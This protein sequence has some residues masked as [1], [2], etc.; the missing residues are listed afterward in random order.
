MKKIIALLALTS[1]SAFASPVV[2]STI[3]SLESSMEVK[4]SSVDA[5]MSLS[6]LV[7][8]DCSVT[9]KYSCVDANDVVKVTIKSKHLARHNGEYLEIGSPVDV[10]IN[11]NN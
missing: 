6:C 2:D 5:P 4:C 10:K 7:S 3:K 11:F 8:R 9:Y 1:I